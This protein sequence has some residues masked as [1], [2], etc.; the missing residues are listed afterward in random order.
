MDMFTAQEYLKIDIANSYG[1]DKEDWDVRISWFNAHE[2]ELDKLN[3]EAESPALYYAGVQAYRDMK[4]GKPI[5]YPISLDATA[6]GI[7]L[8]STLIGCRTSAAAC[9]VVTHPSGSRQDVYTSNYQV[10]CQKIGDTAR[11][12]RKDTKTALMTAMYNS[13]AE[14]RRVFGKGSELLRI[15]Y[16]T[17]KET[18]PGAWELNEAMLGT[19]RPNNLSHD[20]VL[21][22]NFHVHV[23][24]MNVRKTG[25]NFMNRP[26]EV[27]YAVNEPMEQGLSNGANMTHSVDGMVVRELRGRC[28]YNPARIEAVI[29]ALDHK[30]KN[31]KR[32]E[33]HM[34]MKLWSLYEQSGY[35]S[36][37]ILNYLDSMNMGHVNAD[38]IK[39][40]IHSL[41]MKPFKILTV[42][43]CF[44]VH[45]N[46]GNDIRKQYNRVLSDI[47]RSNMLTFLVSQIVG[48]PVSVDKKDD[49]ADEILNANYAL[50]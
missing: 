43:D 27:R 39:E 40:L 17:V 1:L 36:V 10:M 3:K 21:P 20:W 4:A 37:R 2:H 8:L 11:I 42:H 30:G 9:N 50:S 26:E 16:E 6:S 31:E 48:Y 5:G 49:I 29:F 22:D 35:L 24:V 38:K 18:L 13:V 44:R 41:P 46:Y 28:M 14:P 34:V 23:K 32:H 19:W 45:P 7:Q 15:F 12:E 33:D 25:I 47:A